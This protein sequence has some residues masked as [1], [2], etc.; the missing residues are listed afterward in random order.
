M[1]Y[2]RC[3]YCGEFADTDS[4]EGEWDVRKVDSK[5]VYEFVCGICADKYINEDGQLDPDLEGVE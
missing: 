5:K 1:S 3:S 4:G 2:L